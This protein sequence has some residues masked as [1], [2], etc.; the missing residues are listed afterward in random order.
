MKK[1]VHSDCIHCRGAPHGW[2]INER[3]LAH[4]LLKTPLFYSILIVNPHVDILTNGSFQINKR[5]ILTL[6]P[7]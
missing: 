6:N 7:R 4:G 3:F 1:T 2:K 5:D